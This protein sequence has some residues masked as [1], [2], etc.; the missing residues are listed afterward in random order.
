MTKLSVSAIKEGTVID[1]IPAGQAMKIILLL[2]LTTQKYR[3]TIG[4]NLSSQRLGRKDLIKIEGKILTPEETNEIALFAPDVTINTIRDFAVHEKRN[5][6]LPKTIEA[7]L[8]CPNLRC[9]TRHELLPSFFHV[10][11]YKNDVHLTCK[12]CQKVFTRDD[13]K[14]YNV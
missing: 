12:Y 9:V 13:I 10:T 8:V 3:V 5:I 14:E 1:H 2:K 6:S 7:I 11:E 4:L